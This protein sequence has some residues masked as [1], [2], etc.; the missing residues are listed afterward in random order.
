MVISF[1]VSLEKHQNRGTQKKDKP[2]GWTLGVAGVAS[3][4]WGPTP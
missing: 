1:L 4:A 3:R 2:A